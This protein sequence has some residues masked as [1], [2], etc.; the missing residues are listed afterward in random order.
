MRGCLARSVAQCPRMRV[1]PRR[2]RVEN[3]QRV[4]VKRGDEL[5]EGRLSERAGGKERTRE[6]GAFRKGESSEQHARG[7][8]R[9]LRQEREA[10]ADTDA[11]NGDNARART[12][13]CRS[14]R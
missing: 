14:S 6:E 3:R 5:G 9:A 2:G 10:C 13:G 4:R 1:T 8:K 11:V 12:G 7:L